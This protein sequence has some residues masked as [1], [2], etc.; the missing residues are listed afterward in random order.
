MEP[1]SP[2]L[3]LLKRDPEGVED[4]VNASE[5]DEDDAFS[6][7]RCPLCGWQPSASCRWSCVRVNTPEPFFM[8]CGTVWNTFLTRGRCPGCSHQWR[9][10]SCLRCAGW[11]L[12]E[13]WYEIIE[14]SP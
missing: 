14:P 9:W 11:S 1:S 8:G 3:F 10:T 4:L 5:P 6:R 7:I 13:D 12:H 2:Q